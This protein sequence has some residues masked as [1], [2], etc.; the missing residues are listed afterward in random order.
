MYS[1]KP[2]EMS[3]VPSEGAGDPPQSHLSA[4]RSSRVTRH[5]FLVLA[6]MAVLPAG[7]LAADDLT[8]K[9]GKKISGTIV[10]FENGMFRLET[11]YG[12][13]LV[14]KDKVSSIKITGVAAKDAPQKSGAPAGET[15]GSASSTGPPPSSAA[16]PSSPGLPAAAPKPPPLSR[17]LNVPLPAHIDEHEEGNAYINDTF[18]FSMFKPPGWKIFKEGPPQGRISAVVAL[19]SE[20]EQTL[21]FVDRQVWSGAPDLKNDGVETNI[22]NLLEDYQKLSESAADV[23]GSPAIRHNFSG[24]M[25]GVEWHGIALR[26]A[27]GSTVF[28]ILGMTSAESYQFQE[29]VLSKMVRTFRFLEPADAAGAAHGPQA[30]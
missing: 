28:G 12:F 2:M 18:H 22:R 23:S 6:V 11:E 29:A 25:D 13:V 8:L 19:A 17:V 10:G 16:V 24:V 21:L 9:D 4:H 30:P 27:R 3:C 15:T 7:P 1:E 5:F 20:D 26:V 14:Q